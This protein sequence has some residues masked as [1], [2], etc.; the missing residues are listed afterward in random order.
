MDQRD[1]EL[2]DKQLHGLHPQPR[3]DGVMM[4]AIVAVFLA[5]MAAGAYLSAYQDEPMRV[6]SNEAAPAI[7]L[8]NTVPP[9][10]RQ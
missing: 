1:Q 9:A 3:H 2:L 6:A 10:L 7:S 4:L 5:G 8:P